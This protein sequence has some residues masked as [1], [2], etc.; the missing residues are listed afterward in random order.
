MSHFGLIAVLLLNSKPLAAVRIGSSKTCWL[1]DRRPNSAMPSSIEMLL[2]T[3]VA[4]D[5]LIIDR[6]AECT[7]FNFID[8][9][10]GVHS[11]NESATRELI[12]RLFYRARRSDEN[13]HLTDGRSRK[14]RD[15]TLD[16]TATQA[17]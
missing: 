11:S 1:S 16:G 15:G 5:M 3:S 10:T 17:L 7:I 14:V 6:A 13:T 9:A 4:A 12:A 2:A 8:C